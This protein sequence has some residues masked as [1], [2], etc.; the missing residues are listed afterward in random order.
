MTE[1]E[2]ERHDQ[3]YAAF[4][5]DYAAGSL[6]PAEKLVADVH[7]TLSVKGG[8]AARALDAIGGTLLEQTSPRAMNAVDPGG[9]MV[10]RDFPPSEP[11]P[12][13]DEFGRLLSSDL[14]QLP[15]RKGLGGVK[16]LQT[17]IP[18]AHLLR[19]DPGEAA[20]RHAHGRRDVTV[21]LCGSFSDEFGVYTRGDLAFAEPGMKHAPKAVGDRT[22]VCLLATESGRP[23]SG[24]L[25]LFGIPGLGKSRHAA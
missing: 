4:M 22:C 2:T 11:A 21:V 14:M 18:L 8:R 20:P 13:N 3:A 16:T 10:R 25:G 7:R 17:R 6:S 5:L 1:H 12:A 9:W 19:L 23:L 24:L 15:W